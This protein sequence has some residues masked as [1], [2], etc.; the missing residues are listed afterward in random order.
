VLQGH[1]DMVCEKN[2]DTQHDFDREGIR[3]VVDRDP[4]SAR[5]SSAPGHTLGADNGIGV[6]MALAAAT[7]PGVVHGPL[8]LLCTIDEEMGMT[9]ARQLEPA[10]VRGRVLVNL[11]TE[12]DNSLYIGCAGGGD[13]TLTWEFK[14]SPIPA[15]WEI[16]RVAV[17][18]LRGG[19]SGGDITRI[20]ATPS[21]R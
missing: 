1:L 17:T 20:A 9:G 15:A 12:E 14:L 6:A 2:A 7:D 5:P 8:E 10:F 11:D 3:T 16:G 19:H 13:A 4:Q 21:R 18:G